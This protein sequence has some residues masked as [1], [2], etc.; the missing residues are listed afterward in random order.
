MDGDMAVETILESIKMSWRALANPTI[1][2]EEVL[3]ERNAIAHYYSLLAV[4]LG[5]V[6]S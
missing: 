3:L 1:S 6:K 4:A 5:L 2:S